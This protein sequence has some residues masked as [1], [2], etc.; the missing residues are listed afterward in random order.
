MVLDK[1]ELDDS[2]PVP[3]EVKILKPSYADLHHGGSDS[4]IYP[5]LEHRLHASDTINRDSL[6][7]YFYG[8]FTKYGN[9]LPLLG[10]ADDRFVIMRH[11]DELKLEFPAMVEKAGS[12]RKF[13]LYA[14]VYYS[15]KKTVDGTFLRD[16]LGPLP[17]HGMSRY[18]YNTSVENYP[19]D[20][21]HLEYLKEWNTRI[22]E[23]GRNYCYDATGKE[24]DTG[25]ETLHNFL[26]R[27]GFIPG[28]PAE[29][30]P[31]NG[32]EEIH[33][34]LN[35]NY[36]ELKVNNQVNIGAI[37]NLNA[38]SVTSTGS[39][40][41][42][43]NDVQSDNR[44]YY[45]LN[46]ADVNNFTNGNWS[47][48]SNGTINVNIRLSGLQANATYY[49]KPQSWY[50]GSSISTS[51]GNF[52]TL[53]PGAWTSP[54]EYMVSPAG[55]TGSPAN[56]RTVNISAVP[57]NGNGRYIP[58]LSPEAVIYNSAGTEM[59]RAN[60]SGA[61]PYF[62][63]FTLPDYLDEGKY[64]VSI[65]GY[66]FAGE[67]SVLKWACANCHVNNYPSNFTAEYLHPKHQ[68]PTYVHTFHPDPYGGAGWYVDYTTECTSCHSLYGPPFWVTHPQN[69]SCSSC[70]L[71]RP[72]VCENCHNDITTNNSYLSPRYGI[73]KHA[74]QACGNC[75]GTLTS[76][77]TK[78]S[79]PTCHPRPGSNLTSV[80]D[81]IENTTHSTQQTVPCG[82]C[83]NREHDVKT[84]TLENKDCKSCH[85]GISHDG[86]DR[87]T[88][89]HGSDPHRI[90]KPG[91]PACLGCHN[92]TNPRNFSNIHFIDGASFSMGVHASMNS[93]N[94]SGYGINASCWACHNSSG[95]VVAN[96]SH[97]DRRDTPYIC[98]D[99][100]LA[101]GNN[102]GAYNAP[103][104]SNHY[105][106]GTSIRA[107]DNKTSDIAS[108]IQCHE[109]V[110]EMIIPN[111]DP[112]YG[113]FAGDGIGPTGGNTSFY[114]YGR[115][116]NDLRILNSG[117]ADNCSY[118][119]QNA[120][121]AFA[122]NMADPAY[123]SSISNHSLRYN[124]SNPGC[125]SQ[126]C[127]NT[128]WIHNAT[129]TKPNLTLPNSSFCLGC[130]GDNG[131]GSTNFSNMT[132]GVRAMH[133]NSVNCTE[134]HL[135]NSRSI[136][137]MTYLQTNNSFNTS[138]SS[139]V[140]CLT[141]HTTTDVDSTILRY[142]PKIPLSPAHSDKAS[143]GSLWTSGRYWN[144]SNMVTACI[145]CHNDTKHN[146]T[147]LGRLANWKGN[148][149][150]NSTI[151]SGNWCSGCHYSGYS[152]GEE[153]YGNMSASF[154]SAG[155]AVPPEITNGTY[156]PYSFPR[157]YNHSLTDYSDAT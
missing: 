81:S 4:Y 61:G 103:I 16:T 96:N 130:H 46:E 62:N 95:T 36:V 137:P 42:W 13:F 141:C 14:D 18:P 146:A 73:D 116:R 131:N 22:C 136:H 106:N 82:L 90:L 17:F 142:P 109:N 91:G 74:G 88:S 49:Y 26:S 135:N 98:T 38:S 72:L 28:E 12:R 155:L 8:N 27:Y 57:R 154:V 76:M 45:G 122:V 125:T 35:T 157:Y 133:N 128:G 148:N 140:N 21:E 70:H 100:H 51:A 55:W 58:G 152:S 126:Q 134:C 143:N 71:S 87:C 33:R 123:N 147:A 86:G 94:A 68:D 67:F 31:G 79:C 9:V 93:N 40:I 153:T 97:P 115:P 92:T 129:L 145:Y 32:S 156:A 64:I 102:S 65:T 83:H 15:I 138:N 24:I 20:K 25:I 144:S 127:H 52:T 89:C 117:M 60:L 114:H 44:V 66:P 19:Y 39:F 101:G 59:G 37:T 1:I 139:A 149:T 30:I 11:G 108:C 10:E 43:N 3:V 107:L 120:S 53:M 48:W 80:P 110:S 105:R 104:V 150:V 85:T 84:L 78:P 132:T 69:N 7:S 77:I 34:S 5:N 56:F 121:S 99:C 50:S 41:S 63:N 2:R 6:A 47:A 124:A 119:H 29:R 118:C 151:S 75:H 113:L 54:A 112:D 111:T 23:K